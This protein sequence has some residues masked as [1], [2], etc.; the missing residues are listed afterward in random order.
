MNGSFFFILFLAIQFF[1]GAG[2]KRIVWER[3]PFFLY[4]VEFFFSLLIFFA[5]KIFFRGSNKNFGGR[6][7]IFFYFF[8]FLSWKK[9]EGFQ[10][11]FGKGVQFIYSLIFTLFFLRGSTI[12]LA[13]VQIKIG[14]GGV[15]KNEVGGG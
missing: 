9:M 5:A 13:V 12:C 4:W 2:L 7:Q 15:K 1:F 3:V 10:K 6:C 8:Y 14:E 11:F